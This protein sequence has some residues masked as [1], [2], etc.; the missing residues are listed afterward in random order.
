[1]VVDLLGLD[2]LLL[3]WQDVVDNVV[4]VIYQ[5]LLFVAQ[6]TDIDHVVTGRMA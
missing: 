1:V 5:I 3:V 2:L 4:I 6:L